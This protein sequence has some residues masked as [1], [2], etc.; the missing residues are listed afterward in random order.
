MQDLRQV[1]VT[2]DGTQ[3]HSKKEAQDYL[4]R[5]KILE[6]FMA[7]TGQN[8][9]L[10]KWLLENQETVE[11][12]FDI[13]T[14]K[15]VTKSEANKLAKACE[16]LVE[17][18]E[19]NPDPKLAFLVDNIDAVKES[20]RWPKVQ[21][22]SDEEKTVAARNSLLLAS[23]NNEQLVDW[24]IEHREQVLECYNAG[25]PK[26]TV[27]P[28]AAEALARYRE[29]QAAKKAEAEKAAAAS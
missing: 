21:R 19:A 4:R 22:M 2:E 6:A 7:V 16:R 1:Y 18:N 10:S 23:E 11:E 20:F 5:P 12:A 14:I 27:S 15:R 24:V 28:K 29:E 3:F 25:K 8:D 26:R 17:V 9:Q 13:G